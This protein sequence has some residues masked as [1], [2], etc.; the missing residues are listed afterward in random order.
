MLWDSQWK[1]IAQL[2]KMEFMMS[3]L[4]SILSNFEGMIPLLRINYKHFLNTH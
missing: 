4:F 3:D 1:E 2:K